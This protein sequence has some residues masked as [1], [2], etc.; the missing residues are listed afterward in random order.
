M[1]LEIKKMDLF[2]LLVSSLRYSFGRRSYMVGA[3]GDLLRELGPQCHLR[4]HKK[5]IE[6]LR[7]LMTEESSGD[8]YGQQYWT[9]T[10]HSLKQSYEKRR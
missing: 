6:E 4:D 1:Q 10:L 3:C 9:E 2:L 8:D 5:I 7:K